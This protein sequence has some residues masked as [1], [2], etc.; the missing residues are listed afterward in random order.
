MTASDGAA[1]YS[2]YDYEVHEDPYPFYARLRTEAPLYRNDELV[3]EVRDARARRRPRR[4]SPGKGHPP[5]HALSEVTRR[6]LAGSGR[7]PVE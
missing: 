4:P 3:F 6:P 1:H 5:P 7:Q 2:P